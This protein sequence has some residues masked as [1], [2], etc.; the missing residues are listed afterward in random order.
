MGT[1]NNRTTMAT[2]L[3]AARIIATGGQPLSLAAIELCVMEAIMLDSEGSHLAN[4]VA[5]AELRRGRHA[6]LTE[7]Y[8]AELSQMRLDGRLPPGEQG[9]PASRL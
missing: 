4:G 2:Q 7:K 9:G 6:E 1:L 3:A 5:D 8:E